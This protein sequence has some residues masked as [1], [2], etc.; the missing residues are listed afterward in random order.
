VAI[1]LL[2]TGIRLRKFFAFFRFDAR[3]ALRAV[4][5]K[6]GTAAQDRESIVAILFSGIPKYLRGD[7][8][9]AKPRVNSSGDVVF[10]NKELA[11]IKKRI[12]KANRAPVLS[13]SWVILK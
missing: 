1:R 7:N 3:I 6:K 5:Q 12:R 10:T 8:I 11:S 2:K 13:P 9:L 4:S